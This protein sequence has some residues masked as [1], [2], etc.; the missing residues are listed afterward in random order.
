MTAKCLPIALLAAVFTLMMS[1]SVQASPTPVPVIGKGTWE[2]TLLGRD[3]N[4][5]PIDGSLGRAAMLYDT[6]L[7]ITWMRTVDET[8]YGIEG[9]LTWDDTSSWLNN[10]NH[11]NINGTYGYKD[12][13]LPTMVDTYSSPSTG[14]DGCNF[15]YEGGTDCGTNVQTATS[16]MA[17]LYY[18]TLG[19]V[20]YC[21]PLTSTTNSCDSPQ[22]GFGVP[23]IG[24]FLN[25]PSDGLL[26]WS[27]LEDATSG[28]V[29]SAWYFDFGEGYQHTALRVE[30]YHV[31]AVR[32]GDVYVK[33]PNPVPE[34]PSL[35]LVALGFALGHL[36]LS[37]RAKCKRVGTC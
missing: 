16:E 20:A 13:R 17:H 18:V 29:P 11:M 33:P 15:S 35:P 30:K 23:N 31:F 24:D 7:D 34:P 21:N 27:G 4:G 8:A 6:V 25:F 12:W 22:P 19:N 26:F 2:N 5:N 14:A 3:V 28:G 37:R 9:P 32:D 36:M 10:F 1:N